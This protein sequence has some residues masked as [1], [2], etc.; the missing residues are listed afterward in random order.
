[1]CLFYSFIQEQLFKSLL[2]QSNKVTEQEVLGQG[3]DYL[4]QVF[5]NPSGLP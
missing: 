2:R 4:A 5:L 1:M 3:L